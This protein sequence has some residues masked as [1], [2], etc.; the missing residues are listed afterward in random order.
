[1]KVKN[2]FFVFWGQLSFTILV[3]PELEKTQTSFAKRFAESY[4]FG[5]LTLRK[6]QKAQ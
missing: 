5:V 2:I 1:M 6:R 3:A 4:R